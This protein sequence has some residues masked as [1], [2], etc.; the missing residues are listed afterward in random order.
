[1]TERVVLAGLH[2]VVNS[3]LARIWPA[4]Q[5]T[6]P[7]VRARTPI[8]PQTAA[9]TNWAGSRTS[10]PASRRP[11]DGS[12]ARPADAGGLGAWLPLVDG[13]GLDPRDNG[14]S[15]CA[16]IL[17]AAGSRNSAISLVALSADG[18]LRYDFTAQPGNPAAWSQCRP[19]DLAHGL[20]PVERLA[21][22]V[23]VPGVLRDLGDQ[24]Q[25]HPPERPG[26]PPRTRAPGAAA[27]QRPGRAG[28]LSAR[29]SGPRSRR[30]WRAGCP[31]SRRPAS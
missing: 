19:A 1:M 26:L 31:A 15:S 11:R 13:D 3:G 28:S 10:L 9:S 22:D 2:F 29:R 20:R 21:D 5:P 7:P 12:A 16:A 27:A 17:A 30:T 8:P 14:P 25:H 23:G 24:V 6:R 4:K 18:V